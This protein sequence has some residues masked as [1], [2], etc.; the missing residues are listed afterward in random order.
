MQIFRFVVHCVF[1]S[2]IF[3][4]RFSL[5]YLTINVLRIRRPTFLNNNA[6][7]TLRFDIY[8]IA[9]VIL[10]D[11]TALIRKISNTIYFLH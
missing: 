5:T 8:I 4:S 11:L 10:I 7:F 2:R 9:I 1:C 6:I 3:F